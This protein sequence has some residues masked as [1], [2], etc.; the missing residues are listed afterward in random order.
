MKQIGSTRASDSDIDREENKRN[1][2]DAAVFNFINN[3]CEPD[4]TR[5]KI[6]LSDIRADLVGYPNFKMGTTHI[7]QSLERLEIARLIRK[8]RRGGMFYFSAIEDTTIDLTQPNPEY[9]ADAAEATN[10]A[11][12]E[13]NS[14]DVNNNASQSSSTVDNVF[15]PISNL[16]GSTNDKS[17]LKRASTDQNDQLE[18][19][20]VS[21][22][23]ASNVDDPGPEENDS[24]PSASMLN[25]NEDEVLNIVANQVRVDNDGS[26][27]TEFKEGLKLSEYYKDNARKDTA[28]K[29]L[30]VFAGKAVTSISEVVKIAEETEKS[31]LTDKARS[32][33]EQIMRN[34]K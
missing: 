12:F 2:Y 22:L 14:Q 29:P 5:T 15:S 31:L 16:S 18:S 33:A 10:I 30:K 34:G 25:L 9:S 21:K 32:R 24:R 19:N 11:D 13:N 6:N 23:S 26:K 8:E 17:T 4:L 20:K 3:A 7:A 1:A 28:A 27:V